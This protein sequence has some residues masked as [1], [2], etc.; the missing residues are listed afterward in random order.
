MHRSDVD[1]YAVTTPSPGTVHHATSVAVGGT[2]WATIFTSLGGLATAGALLISLVVLWQQIRTQRQVQQDRH[3]EHASH[4]SFWLTLEGT[5]RKRDGTPPEVQITLHMTNTSERPAMR[6]LALVGIR[7]DV[8]RNASAAD[9]VRIEEHD[10]EWRAVALAPD[11]RLTER[12]GLV[13]PESVAT[14]VEDCGEEALVGELLFTDAA[15]VAWVKTHDGQLIDRKSSVYAKNIY[16][17]LAARDEQRQ[18]KSHEDKTHNNKSRK[19]SFRR[20]QPISQAP[21][22]SATKPAAAVTE[23]AHADDAESGT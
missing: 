23:T 14:I 3:R 7:A 10:V 20:S 19:F 5:F 15:G 9:G 4:I 2:P 12:L 21:S 11:D 6:M 18:E 1:F 17:S 8:W 16:L 13:V 22:S